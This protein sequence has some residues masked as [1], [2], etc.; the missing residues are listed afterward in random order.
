MPSRADIDPTDIVRFLPGVTLLDVVPDER[1]YVYRLVGTREVAMR[2][3]DPTGKSVMDAFYGDS[4]ETSLASY[5][6]VV[7]GRKP[8]FENRAF[9]T[10]EGR[11]G[12]EEVVLLPLSD[13]GVT[14]TKVLAYTHHRLR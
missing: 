3:R 13:D 1:R 4:P 5:D 8:I 2:G 9:V 6:A 12:D 14:V 11:Y 10:P 7:N